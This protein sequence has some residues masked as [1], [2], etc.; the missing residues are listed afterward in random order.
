[1]LARSFE[2]L[3]FKFL[4]EAA[5]ARLSEALTE[6]HFAAGEHVL[7]RGAQDDDRVFLLLEGSVTSTDSRG[8]A[9]VIDAGHYFGERAALFGLKRTHEVIARTACVCATFPGAALL[10]EV[11]ASEVFAQAL[12]MML[13][14]KQRIFADFERFLAELRHG[15]SRGHIVIPRL[16]H[17]YRPLQ[18]ALHR[19]ASGTELDLEALS[20]ATA[21]LPENLTRTLSW[22]V[23]DELP[24]TYSEPQRRYPA[25]ESRARRRAVYEMMPGKNLV[26][27]RDG[28]TDLVDL[29]TCLCVYAVEARKLRMR[30]GS[31]HLL[32][33]LSAGNEVA[34]EEVFTDDERAAL[35]RLWPRLGQTLVDI[36]NHHE[37]FAIRVYKSL[38][39]YNSAHSERWTHQVARATELLLGVAPHALPDDFE[40]HVISSNTH[41]VGNCLSS[42]LQEQRDVILAWGL[43]HRPDQCALHWS[44]PGDLLVALSRPYFAAHPEAEAAR[45]VADD[46]DG[47]HRLTETAFTGIGVQLFD[48]R[49]L[50]RAG[51]DPGVTRDS[52]ARPGLLINIDYAFGQQA[53]SIIAN[54]IALF[55][56]H[57]RSI[58][59]L[60]KAGGLA[61]KRGDLIVA[62][63]FIEQESD[64]LHVP[65]VDVDVERLRARLPHRTVRVGPA[66]TVLGTILQNDVLLNFYKRIWR[67]VGLEMEGSYYCRQILESQRLGVLRDDVSLRFLYY[68]SDI[69]LEPD[70]TLSGRLAAEEGI[71]PLYAATREVLSAIF[72]PPSPVPRSS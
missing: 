10:A 37:D 25:I 68:I 5:R 15:A 65:A 22:F 35:H 57:I 70:E 44:D 33:G 1:M 36:A 51:I 30:V 61:G 67:C 8:R 16:L 58:N 12:G 24:Y 20:Y 55:G 11:E 2:I 19:H 46:H 54:L 48:L 18:P 29:I 52:L 43:A 38:D 28:L 71:P 40:V 69:P 66:L 53:G 34:L 13:R 14:D 17:L 39:N 72:A 64:T 4:G 6:H 26:L 50:N 63:R 21:R 27:L 62:T 3:P 49:K 47:A 60:G 31:P 56:H 7:D 23:T 45:A 32:L 59:V 42:W 9:N 41:S